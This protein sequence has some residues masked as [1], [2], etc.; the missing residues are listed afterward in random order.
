MLGWIL[1]IVIPLVLGIALYISK[2]GINYT[3]GSGMFKN[4]EYN[5]EE[6]QENSGKQSIWDKNMK[7]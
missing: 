6:D 5:L 7:D 4:S 1:G 3:A 2:N